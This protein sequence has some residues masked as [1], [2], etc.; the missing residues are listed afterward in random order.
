VARGDQFRDR[1]ARLEKAVELLSQA[2]RSKVLRP[3]YARMNPRARI[4]Y[5]VFYFGE[6]ENAPRA[7]L[8][9]PWLY[10][11]APDVTFPEGVEPYKIQEGRRTHAGRF[12]ARLLVTSEESSSLLSAAIKSLRSAA[13]RAPKG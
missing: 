4:K 11:D 5:N 8:R 9:G 3:T 1:R 10:F 7:V 6:R 12:N 13:G 2:A